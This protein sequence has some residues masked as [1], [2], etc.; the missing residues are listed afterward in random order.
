MGKTERETVFKLDEKIKL[1][2]AITVNMTTSGREFN[3][4][5]GFLTLTN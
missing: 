2:G 4:K 3:F 1:Y 5:D